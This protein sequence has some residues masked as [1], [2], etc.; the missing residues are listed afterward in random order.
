MS[1]QLYVNRAIHHGTTIPWFLYDQPHF[2]QLP[3][4]SQ[5][6]LHGIDPGGVNT[7][8]PQ[9][10]RQFHHSTLALAQRRA[11]ISAQI[12]LSAQPLPASCEKDLP[13]DDFSGVFYQLS[14]QF[15]RQK[16]GPRLPFK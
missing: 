4:V 9:D 3:P 6:A 8:V 15:S 5:P 14:V 10:V 1:N 2:L 16:D 7:A 13:R 11:F 12:W